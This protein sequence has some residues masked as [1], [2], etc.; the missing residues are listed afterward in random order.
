MIPAIG[1]FLALQEVQDLIFIDK[2]LMKMCLSGAGYRG[3]GHADCSGERLRELT[4]AS[5]LLRGLGEV[6]H[7]PVFG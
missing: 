2:L 7:S 5:D 6:L 1:T 4:N 3:L